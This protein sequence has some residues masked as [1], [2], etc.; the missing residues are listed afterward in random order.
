MLLYL[1]WLVVKILSQ[2]VYILKRLTAEFV[3][4]VYI[5]NGIH[6]GQSWWFCSPLFFILGFTAQCDINFR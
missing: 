2:L 6:C 3:A 5:V 4:R 1:I